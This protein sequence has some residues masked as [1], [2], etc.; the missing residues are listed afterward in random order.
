MHE[1]VANAQCRYC[2]ASPLIMDAEAILI[3]LG[4]RQLASRIQFEVV[5]QHS[6]VKPSRQ[7]LKTHIHVDNSR[8][9]HAKLCNLANSS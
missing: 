6:E 9:K 1:H 3:E 7:L 8:R 5:H 4:V 2:T